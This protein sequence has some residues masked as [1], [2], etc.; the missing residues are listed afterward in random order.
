MPL[1]TTAAPAKKR[2]LPEGERVDVA[3]LILPPPSPVLAAP[4]LLT[5]EGSPQASVLHACEDS[6]LQLA[7]PFAGAG[8]VQVRVWMPPPHVAE[9][10]PKA[11]Q[12]PSA[13]GT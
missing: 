7:P 12:P 4:V 6:P 8:F 1:V 5:A 11:V 13:R 2:M 9:H 3:A 10:A